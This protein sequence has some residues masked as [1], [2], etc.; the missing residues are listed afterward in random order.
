MSTSISVCIPTYNGSLYIEEQLTSILQQL[1]ID[2]EIIISDDHSTDST[3]QKIE[4]LKDHRIKIFTN[5]GTQG[6]V[7]NTENALKQAKGEFIFLADQDDIWYPEKIS[8]T[9][10]LLDKYDLVL[11]DATV[12][13][14]LGNVLNESFYKANKSGRGLIKNWYRNSF[15]GCCMA[16]NRTH[17]TYVLPFPSDL[18]MHDSWIGLNAILVGK[19]YI[20]PRPLIYYRRHGENASPSFEKS[21]FT[22]R[23]MISY[24]LYMMYHAVL[25]R[26]QH[27]LGLKGK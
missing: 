13:D 6:P 14:Q 9:V 22:I 27:V 20:L 4:G 12:I 18:A 17:L 25:R 3:L 10:P 15:I 11:S 26:L 19:Y 24:R 23:Y 21:D 16:F 7:Y 1:G 8:V 2:D 5:E